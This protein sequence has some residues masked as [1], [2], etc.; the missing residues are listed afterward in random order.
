MHTLS[1]SSISLLNR[2]FLTVD[3]NLLG[4]D[5]GVA[6]TGGEMLAGVSGNLNASKTR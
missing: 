3:G 6:T 5:A 1:S 4:N 2:S